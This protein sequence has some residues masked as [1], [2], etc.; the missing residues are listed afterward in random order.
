MDDI[1]LLLNGEALWRLKRTSHEA[2][3]SI[4]LDSTYSS[5]KGSPTLDA[6]GISMRLEHISES[7]PR[8][9]HL[10]VLPLVLVVDDF[11]LGEVDLVPVGY[12]TDWS[13]QAMRGRYSAYLMIAM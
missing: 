6:L 9:I 5:N 11:L 4:Q 8:V 1:L 12:S 7:F 3:S 10:T 13:R 2:V